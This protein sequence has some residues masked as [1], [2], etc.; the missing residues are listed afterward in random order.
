MPRPE[1]AFGWQMAGLAFAIIVIASF[2]VT[3]LVTDLLHVRRRAY[4]AILG[5]M[6]L[7]LGAA[8]VAWSGTPVGEL[9]TARWGWGLVAGVVAAGVTAPLV[10][11]LPR[12]PHP[13][14]VRLGEALLWEGIVYGFAEGVL[15]AALPVLAVWQAMSDR[16]WA[17]GGWAKAASGAMAIA[18]ALLV[19]LIHHL[20]YTEFRARAARA[21]L[22]GA[23]VTCGS[24]LSRSS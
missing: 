14:G 24:S 17:E 15:L 2:L 7:A 9:V 12:Q 13:G 10:R 8:Y 11:R 20:G 6:V 3:W 21:K 1:P 19:I 16:G 23:L 22:V 18:G 5:L 4:V